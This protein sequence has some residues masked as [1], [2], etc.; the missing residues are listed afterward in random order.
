MKSAHSIIQ[1]LNLLPHP[2]GGYYREIYRSNTQ[3][4]S[5]KSNEN[6][7]A[8][9]CIYFLLTQGQKSCFH[10]V[11]HDEIWHFYL[12]APLR[13]IDFHTSTGKVHEYILGDYK[14]TL[15]AQQVIMA[16]HWQ[17]AESLGEYSLVGCSV[18][19]GFD[20]KDFT[21]L[22]DHQDSVIIEKQHPDLHAFI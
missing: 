12:G 11:K 13:L 20:F 14:H 5:Q 18:A 22:K 15:C 17:A 10:R 1:E 16:N 9:T 7:S 8:I 4:Y 21:F 19:P 6:R 3:V 2:E